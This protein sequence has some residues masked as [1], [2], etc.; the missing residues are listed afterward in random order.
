MS[1]AVAILAGG[2]GRRIGGSKPH[3]LLGGI[4]LLD[5][6]L[7]AARIWAAPTALVVRDADQAAGFDGLVILDDPGIAGPL[8]GLAAALAWGASVGADRVLTIPCDMPFLP[9]DLPV[10]LTRA[11]APSLGAAVAAS[12]GRTHP[13]CA[14]WRTESARALSR[15]AREGRLSLNGLSQVVG[16]AVVDWPTNVRDPF[17]NI[18]TENDLAAAGAALA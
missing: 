17:L 5:H 13:V 11:L 3:R 12:G 16:R 1:L 6:A 2:A 10:R 15:E 18:N 4:S 9:S 7:S 14:I 8:S